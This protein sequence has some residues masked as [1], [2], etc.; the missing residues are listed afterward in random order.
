MIKLGKQGYMPQVAALKENVPVII[1]LFKDDASP[2]FKTFKDLADKLA[3][4]ATFGHS[5]DA[6][7]VKGV[8]KAPSVTIFKTDKVLKYDGKFEAA[9]LGAWVESKSAPTLIDLE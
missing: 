9:A 1:G 4:D 8:A 5:F 2:E 6:K 3:D 7:L